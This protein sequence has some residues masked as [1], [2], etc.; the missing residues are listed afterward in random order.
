MRQ[1]V[2]WNGL[3]DADAVAN[4][5]DLRE[6]VWRNSGDDGLGNGKSILL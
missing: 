6:A 2:Q 5:L 3:V 4:T 1:L